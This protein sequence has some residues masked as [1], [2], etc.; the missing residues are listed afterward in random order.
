MTLCT[1][2]AG[3]FPGQREAG[4]GMVEIDIAP[5]LRRVAGTAIRAKLTVVIILVGVAGI[6]VGGRTLIPIGVASLTLNAGMFSDQREA[7]AAVIECDIRPFR[8]FMT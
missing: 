3:M 1:T 8:R 5:A 6:T 4:N 2:Q 7:R